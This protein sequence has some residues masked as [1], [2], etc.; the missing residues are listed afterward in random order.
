MVVK[1]AEGVGKGRSTGGKEVDRK[2]KG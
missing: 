2:R 1:Q